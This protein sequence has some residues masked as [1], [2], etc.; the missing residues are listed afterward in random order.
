M[1]AEF[2]ILLPA[3]YPLTGKPAPQKRFMVYIL[4]ACVFIY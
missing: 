2:Y 4:G 1:G 3:F